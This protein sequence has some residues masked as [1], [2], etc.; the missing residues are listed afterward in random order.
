MEGPFGKFLK[1]QK[2][3]DVLRSSIKYSIQSV[4][5]SLHVIDEIRHRERFD[6]VFSIAGKEK[7]EK[8]KE[9]SVVLLEKMMVLEK[10]LSLR[11]IGK[12]KAEFER[13]RKS[14]IEMRQFVEEL[15]RSMR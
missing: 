6:Q 11:N 1:A 3:H 10:S 9:I 8:N 2:D 7:I 4:Q 12:I 5:R 14:E 13:P 15:Q